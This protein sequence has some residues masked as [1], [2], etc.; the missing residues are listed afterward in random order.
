MSLANADA[1][2]RSLSDSNL[3]VRAVHRFMLDGVEVTVFVHESGEGPD[4]AQ[5]L[6]EG[7]TGVVLTP[8][9]HQLA[10]LVEAGLSQL[11]MADRLGVSL[12]T[13]RKRMDALYKT[14]RVH[15]RAELAARLR[16]KRP[17]P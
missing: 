17:S 2:S 3:A 6:P 10:R 16:A 5:T 8:A 9:M 12:G 7:G 14:Y 4:A 1:M 11:E 15:S 13:V